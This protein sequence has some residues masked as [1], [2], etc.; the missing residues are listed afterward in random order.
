M[1]VV[2]L[3]PVGRSGLF[4]L[5]STR[6]VVASPPVLVK[7]MAGLTT[8][9]LTRVCAPALTSAGG[10]LTVKDTVAD[11]VVSAVLAATMLTTT[12]P[13]VASNGVPVI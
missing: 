12:V 7:T 13:V 2:V 11:A 6:Q 1:T 10:A 9:S 8:R 5:V 3:S 4:S